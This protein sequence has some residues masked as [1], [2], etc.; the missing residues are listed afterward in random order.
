MNSRAT[1]GRC[2]GAGVLWRSVRCS[3]LGFVLCVLAVAGSL[4][5]FVVRRGSIPRMLAEA[6]QGSAFGVQLAMLVGLLCLCTALPSVFLRPLPAG[7]VVTAASVGSLALLQTV[8]VAGLAA[9]LVSQYRLGR[10]GHGVAAV[11]CA[12]PFLVFALAG[13]VDLDERVRVVLLAALAPMA[14]CAGLARRSQVAEREHHAVREV[15]AGSQWENVARSERARIVHELHDVVGHHIS[16]I[17]VQAETARVATPGMPGA[18]A[19]RL[20]GIGDTA[21]AALT[22]MRRLLGVLREDTAA[23]GATGE[24]RP[25]PDL[26]RLGEL[27][28]E[29]RGASHA[30]IRLILSGSPRVLAQGVELVAYR[31]VQESLTNARK[32]A[33]GHPVDVELHYG[34]ADLHLSVRDNGP[35]PP[36]RNADTGHG[37]LGMRERVAAVGGTIR[38]G[39]G[40]RGGFL[41]RATFPVRA[42]VPVRAGFPA[43]THMNRA[44]PT[45]ARTT[46]R[47][48]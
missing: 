38:T 22:E 47:T 5:E 15:M 13:S 24:R 26:S 48:T 39:P 4:A 11:L 16:M 34:E 19:E 18:G 10:R 8:T 17:A 1:D 28:D 14:A 23:D 21:R 25:Q 37:L 45:S 46:E 20:L 43:G 44:R 2:R 31:I 40:E 29:A 42:T 6:S 27:L 3:W 32:H 30:T 41:V 12:L 9:Q 33:P 35:G 36:P 7:V